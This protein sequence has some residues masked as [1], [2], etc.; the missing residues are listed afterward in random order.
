MMAEIKRERLGNGIEHVS[1]PVG[2]ISVYW[3]IS[4][5]SY[6][7]FADALKDAGL[8]DLVPAEERPVTTLRRALS[9]VY[10]RPYL[11]RPLKGGEG[12]AVVLERKGVAANR[13]TRAD[14]QVVAK[15]SNGPNGPVISYE[16]GHEPSPDEQRK[17]LDAFI[18]L[19]DTLNA[20]RVALV[21]TDTIL[22]RLNG[23][24]LRNRGGFYWIPNASVPTWHTLAKCVKDSALRP[25][26]V[27]FGKITTAQSADTVE[28][29]RVAII[30]EATKTVAEIN[31]AIGN[32]KVGARA[33]ET[34]H[35]TAGELRKKVERYERLLNVALTDVRKQLGD[36]RDAALAASYARAAAAKAKKAAGVAVTAETQKKLA[37]SPF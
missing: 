22:T 14:E 33:L 18:K 9:E 8:D 3:E 27:T 20:Q 11:V 28:S 29:L 34:Q 37:A 13:Y 31:E 5:V 2:G 1:V 15:I 21:L 25:D 6:A 16:P 4:D 35:K 10:A 12:Y 7:K 23:V 19:A 36:V 30:S 26:G 32:E 17:V 24:T